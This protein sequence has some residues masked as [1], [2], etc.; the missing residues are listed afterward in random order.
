MALEKSIKRFR[1]THGEVI[2]EHDAGRTYSNQTWA[3]DDKIRLIGISMFLDVGRGTLSGGCEN[4]DV[5]ADLA[6]YSG[7]GYDTERLLKMVRRL[8]VDDYTIGAAT[9]MGMFG[10][11]FGEL[12]MMFPSGYGI[13]FEKGDYLNSSLTLNALNWNGGNASA[14]GSVIFYYVE[15]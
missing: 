5:S 15:R 9:H 3:I 4:S 8:F 13:D 2:A 6:C 1:L 10:S 14:S 11:P 12:V 7:G